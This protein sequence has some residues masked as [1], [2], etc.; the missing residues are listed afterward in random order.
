MKY[1]ERRSAYRNLYILLLCISVVVIGVFLSMYFGFQSALWQSINT[2]SSDFVNQVNS[3]ASVAEGVLQNLS[4]QIYNIHSVK[5]LRTYDELSNS[6]MIDGLRALND[7]T[8]SSSVIDSI[9]VY[10]GKQDYV[11]STLSSGAVSDHA[12]A[13]RDQDALQLMQNKTASQRLQPIPRYSVSSSSSANR[14]MFSILYFDLTGNGGTADNVMMLNISSRWFAELYLGTEPDEPAL[15]MDA[16]GNVIAAT[17]TRPIEDARLLDELRAQL[18]K[19][20]NTANFVWTDEHGTKQLCLF[21]LMKNRDW[22]YARMLP[23]D[24]H[25]TGLTRMESSVY[26]TVILVFIALMI[27]TVLIVVRVWMPF[28]DIRVSL[29][30]INNARESRKNPV[31]QLNA[32]ISQSADSNRI[33]DALRRMLRDSVLSGLLLGHEKASGNIAAEYDMSLHDG[34]AIIPVFV[35]TNRLEHLMDFVRPHFPAS[36]AV[37][38]PDDHTVLLVQPADH[39]AV[40]ELCSQMVSAYPRWSVVIGEAVSAWGD[41]SGSYNQLVEAYQL[42]LLYDDKPVRCISE[43]PALEASSVMAEQQCERIIEALRLG[44]DDTVKAAYRT[45]L[46]LLNGKTYQSVEFSL[47]H[48]ARSVLKL[49]YELFPEATP[50]Y[51]EARKEFVLRLQQAEKRLDVDRYFFELFNPI[52]EK[53]RLERRERQGQLPEAIMR[54]IQEQFRDPALSL[55]MLADHFSMSSAYLGRVFRQTHGM[56]VSECING[57]RIEEAKRLLRETDVKIKDFG[58]LIGVENIQYFFVQFKAATG[59]TPKQYRLNQGREE[60]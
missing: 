35:S 45:F 54:M 49:Y 11:Y 14:A 47:T 8:A 43:L 53:T 18:E 2:L 30:G 39:Q 1:P 15:M 12:Y 28:Q 9:Y 51:K 29:S 24:K 3:T 27:G 55:Q 7:F 10:N 41:L 59:M 26:L 56:S 33:N 40:V 23:Y 21:T 60:A 58:P 36:E 42:R 5:K 52:T 57:L 20:N 22:Y 4:A 46:D 19:G 48:L 13:F 34:E 37:S 32:L 44:N 17:E 38:V 25:L 16:Q 50:P 31:E 6:D